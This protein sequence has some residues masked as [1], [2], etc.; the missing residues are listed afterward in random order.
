MTQRVLITG[1]A[2]NV[3]KHLQAAFLAIG[4]QVY[5]IDSMPA[6]MHPLSHPLDTSTWAMYRSFPT[7]F[8][9][10]EATMGGIDTLVNIGV[11]HTLAPLPVTNAE[12]LHARIAA[13]TGAIG[14]SCAAG[15]PFLQRQ[16]GNKSMVNIWLPP[17]ETVETPDTFAQNDFIDLITT[18]TKQL[19]HA[20][21]RAGILVT[22]LVQHAVT[23]YDTHAEASQIPAWVLFLTSGQTMTTNGNVIHLGLEPHR[24]T[25]A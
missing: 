11:H 9:Q 13:Y 4:A 25:S 16:P 3:N 14:I 1:T 6:T 15:I 24:H 12:Q 8:A 18:Q 2:R 22:T 17:T 19:A 23:G 5:C 21:A 20:H 10:A 7:S